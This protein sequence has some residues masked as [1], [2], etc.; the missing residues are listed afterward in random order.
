MGLMLEGKQ[1]VKSMLSHVSWKLCYSMQSFKIPPVLWL[2]LHME[3]S[4]QRGV[5]HS[6]GQYLSLKLF[7]I[8]SVHNVGRGVDSFSHE[9][10]A[11]D[12][13]SDY[14]RCHSYSITI[15]MLNPAPGY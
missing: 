11:L 14:S 4:I 2:E 7:S 6:V 15:N 3:V 8:F 12:T 10:G 1:N 5:R 13:F 9:C